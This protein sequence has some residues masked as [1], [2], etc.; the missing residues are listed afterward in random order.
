VT[1]QAVSTPRASSAGRTGLA[2][3]VVS[4]ATFG[5]SGT[6]ATSLID[7]GW[8]P[9]AAVLARIAAAAAVLTVPGVLALRGRWGQLRRSAG[10]VAA[11]GLFAVA[12]AQLCYFN[13]IQRIPI[14]VALLLEY[15]G[16]V[17][18][19]GWMWL[20]H[21]QRPSRL[22]I[23]GAVTALAGLG[24]VLDLSGSARLSPVGVMWGL[25][26]AVGL[27]VYFVLSASAEPDA[28]P[29][30]AM[31][32]AGMCVGVVLL[33]ALG[34]ARLLP[35]TVGAGHVRFLH[36]QVSWIVPVAGLSLVAAVIPYV[37]GIAAARRLGA[38]LSSF[39][40]LAEVL[41]AVLWAWLLLGQLPTALQFAGGALI[42]AGVALVRLAESAPSAATALEP[43]PEP[44]PSPGPGYDLAR[45]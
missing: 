11:F 28:L 2:L 30:L 3:A 17:L 1:R 31:A 15:L 40:G 32:W 19:V 14:G 34:L 22:T 27:A 35:M 24:L 38:R 41:F 29:P 36:D 42:L 6:F 20:R 8:S 45:P 26:A 7:A 9:G 21:A 23:A 39:T 5:T 25:L 13:A 4:A 10:R 16:V 43:E 44:E 33:A 12:G 37:T 18:V